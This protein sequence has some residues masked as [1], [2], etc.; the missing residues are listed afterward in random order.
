MPVHFIKYSHTHTRA[1]NQTTEN[2]I[3]EKNPVWIILYVFI[4][5]PF[6]TYYY[7]WAIFML[8][9]KACFKFV[10]YNKSNVGIE[11]ACVR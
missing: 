11:N 10:S 5:I 9:N 3:R 2:S 7:S 1:V 4:M 8:M 6:F